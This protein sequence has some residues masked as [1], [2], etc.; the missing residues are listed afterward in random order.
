MTLAFWVCGA[1]TLVSA[2][3]SAGYALAGWRA[4]S[5]SSK[6]ASAYALARS[7]A[8]LIVAAAA[9]FVS[10]VAFLAAIAVAMTLVQAF[11]AVIGAVDKDRMKTVGPAVLAVLN[12][13]AVVWLL[14]S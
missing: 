4:A 10:S 2:G 7:V 9:L 12:T 1:V 6:S 13:A 11:D 5:G 3:V 8:L 14:A